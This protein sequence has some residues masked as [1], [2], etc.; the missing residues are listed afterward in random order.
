MTMDSS[1]KT[2]QAL[3]ASVLEDGA[4]ASLLLAW[5]TKSPDFRIELVELDAELTSQFMELARSEAALLAQKVSIAYDPE[6]ILRD[7]Q[8]TEL[9]A[10]TLPVTNLFHQLS[11]F[12]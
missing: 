8:Y 6:W 1:P 9:S 2:R 5:K 7:N 10:D 3:A 11:D 12:V 4:R